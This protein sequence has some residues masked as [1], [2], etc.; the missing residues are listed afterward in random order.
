MTQESSIIRKIWQDICGLMLAFAISSGIAICQDWNWQHPTPQGSRYRGV[1]FLDTLSG[2][3][4]NDANWVQRTT[5]GGIS[6]HD[7][8]IPHGPPTFYLLDVR[9]TSATDGWAV[10]AGNPPG[11]ASTTNGGETWTYVNIPGDLIGGYHNIGAVFFLDETN[12]FVATD[13]LGKIYKTTDRGSSWNTVH[14]D[15]KFRVFIDLL[16]S[17]SLRGYAISDDPLLRTTNGGESWFEDARVES[18]VTIASTDSDHVWIL[19]SNDSVAVTVDGGSNWSMFHCGAAGDGQHSMSFLDTSHGWIAGNDGMWVTTNGGQNWSKQPE[20][21]SYNAV[22]ILSETRAFATGGATLQL[23]NRIYETTNSGLNWIERSSRVTE[24]RLSA[25]DFVDSSNGWAAGGSTILRTTNSGNS[26]SVQFVDT[27]SISDIDFFDPSTALA[28]AGTNMLRTIDSGKTWAS[29]ATGFPVPTKKV[30]LLNGEIAWSV[31]GD[32]VGDGTEGI[33]LR[34]SNN[35][36]T[37]EDRTPPGSGILVSVLFLDPLNGW[38][39]QAG[40]LYDQPI[41]Y[42]TTDGGVNWTTQIDTISDNLGRIRF[43]DSFNGWIAATD[44]MLRTTD[45]GNSWA[46]R[47]PALGAGLA[48]FIFQNL[49][50]GWAI[51]SLGEISQ[52][53]DGGE[54]W[55]QQSSKTALTLSGIDFFENSVWVVGLFGSIIH[56]RHGP[57]TS[58]HQPPEPI[59]PHTIRIK[60]A[61]P[62]PFNSRVT[63]DIELGQ[64]ASQ[65]KVSVMNIL[66]Q[67]VKVLHDGFLEKGEHRFSWEGTTLGHQVASSGVYFFVVETRSSLT[68]S[69]ICLTK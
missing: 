3:T 27:V 58:S 12:G 48:D 30:Q 28:A 1:Q 44:G 43:V 24:A 36:L 68:V 20:N 64:T 19:L 23:Q 18:P 52:T 10:M 9:F 45:G 21:V 11:I 8:S 61:Y 69:K 57:I 63:V 14:S 53:D 51:S 38:I 6:W 41:L 13:P 26:W 40:N 65:V 22:S 66:G 16:F 39:S 46:R 56:L 55:Q 5:D 49:Q 33:A 17:D 7:V 35:G 29:I 37:W 47:A 67:A 31:G 42:R 25:V 59:L 62:N 2:W 34:S 54:T 50:V 32:Y 15:F 4:W 60:P